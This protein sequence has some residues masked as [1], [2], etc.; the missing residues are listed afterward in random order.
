MLNFAHLVTIIDAGAL[1]N[2]HAYG[3]DHGFRVITHDDGAQFTALC[4]TP[5]SVSRPITC[6]HAVTTSFHVA[7]ATI[8]QREHVR[9]SHPRYEPPF[10]W[11]AHDALMGRT[12]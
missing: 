11:F 6:R 5:D 1:G 9:G 2:A 10:D 12:Q 7:G 3:L 8:P 4:V